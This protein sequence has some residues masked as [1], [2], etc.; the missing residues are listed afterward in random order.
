MKDL[1]DG[2]RKFRNEAFP[3]LEEQ[4]RQLGGMQSPEVLFITCSDSRIVP[5]LILQA[6]PGDLFI[7]RNVGNVVPPVG[8]LIEGTASAIEYAVEV[9]KVKYV[10]LC[11]HSDCGAT[12]AVLD[13]KDLT[14]LP[15]TAQWLQYVETAWQYSEP[16]IPLDDFKGRHTALTRANIIAQLA[17]LKTHPEVARGLTQGSLQVHGWYYDIVTGSI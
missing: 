8:E 4:F 9:L 16:G 2:Y 12:K 3:Q 10:I 1:L 7:C 5:S 15:I 6:E 11:G 14:S 13:Q 17:N